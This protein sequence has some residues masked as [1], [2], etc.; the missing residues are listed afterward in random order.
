MLRGECTFPAKA[1]HLEVRR[2]ESDALVVNIPNLVSEMKSTRSSTFW[3]R[4]GS[5]AFFSL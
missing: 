5:S 3:G 2:S 1:M 4:G